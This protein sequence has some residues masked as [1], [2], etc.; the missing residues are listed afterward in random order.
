ML[1]CGII[2]MLP[3]I[4]SGEERE[5]IGIGMMLRLQRRSTW[6]R[7]MGLGRLL[8]RLMVCA[9]YMGID[10]DMDGANEGSIELR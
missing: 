1:R 4:M 2:R 3:P 10:I 5:L 7:R 9:S 8:I 6:V